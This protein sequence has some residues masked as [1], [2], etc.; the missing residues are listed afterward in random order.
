MHEVKDQYRLAG[1]AVAVLNTLAFHGQARAA[2]EPPI[3][4]VIVSGASDPRQDAVAAKLAYTGIADVA[5]A[6]DV[7]SLPDLTALDVLRRLP[8]VALLPVLDNERPRDTA[9]APVI[10][11]L[12]AA[13]N[14]VTIDGI[15]VASPG[16][17]NGNGSASRGARLNL[18][19]S[20]MI[21][22]MLVSKT[23]LPDQDA[24]GIGG[25][26][27]VR[28]RSAFALGGS[29]FLSVEAALGKPNDAA[30]PHRH[31]R[32][33]QRLA[34][35]AS[36]TFGPQRQ[37]GLVIAASYQATASS[38]NAHMTTDS[39]SE[40]FYNAAGVLQGGA[41]QGNGFAVPQQDKYWYSENRRE[42]Y[43]LAAKLEAK[44]S[45][46]LRG[47]ATGGRFVSRDDMERNELI[48]D[49]RN[50]AKVLGQAA[51][52]GRYPAG[53]VEVGYTRQQATTATSLLQTGLDW[54][55]AAQQV[56]SL[57]AGAS[58]A[59]YREPILMIKYSTGSRNSPPGTGDTSPTP[60]PD[61]A[62]D[63]NT[64]SLDHSF[65]I[66]PAAYYK[67]EN[68]RLNYYRPDSGFHRNAG[69][70]IKY[71]RLDF[72]H[73]GD[74]PGWGYAVGTSF[75]R[76]ASSY[77]LSRT[78]FSPN[79]GA[80]QGTLSDVLGPVGP[81]LIYNQSGLD[82]LTIDPQR[83]A[84]YVDTLRAAGGLN[85]VDQTA[86]GNQ[87]NYEH[88]ERIA[89]A[90]GMLGYAA[91]AWKTRFGVHLDS[92]RQS[93]IGRARVAGAWTD[94]PT[95]SRYHFALPSALASYQWSP[96]LDVRMGASQSIGRPAYD[97]YAARS[98]IDFA[99]PGERGNANATGV[100]VTAGNPDIKP[101]LSTNTDLGVN[102]KLP[103]QAGG[104]LS[105]TVFNKDIKDEIFNASS[106]GYT[107]EGVSYA[108]AVVTKPVN[109]ASASIKGLEISAVVNSLAWLHPAARDFGFSANWTLLKGRM[110]VLKSDKRTRTIGHLTGQP[111]Q[112]RNLSIF[113][114]NGALEL[115]AAYN[116]QGQAL[117][118]VV[119]DIEWQ[120]LYWA[121]RHQV[122]LQASYRLQPGLTL[123]AQ[124]QNL[125]G[126][127][128]TSTVG[129]AGK[130]LKDSHSIPTLYWFGL[131][132]TPAP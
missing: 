14:P 125:T 92:T 62:I 123:L 5:G 132:Y 116:R 51:T 95:G 38:A 54:E 114:G 87:D 43:G 15:P 17:A 45:G 59:S 75:T 25:A 81:G 23:F 89:G 34:G 72:R 67:L 32:I 49:P 66:S 113:Y 106:L 99:N 20:S 42:Q 103:P 124:A 93:T 102:W 98:S 35:T 120:D 8:G 4:E 122:D 19:P 48:I 63:Y 80:K 73:N 50:R 115:R 31:D 55:T 76:D 60:T 18:L 7:Q 64:E 65:N 77:S 117:R 69:N 86:L 100:T 128:L 11:G 107:Y 109:A 101:R 41:N 12:G 3:P 74:G 110:E 108:N 40:S 118:A 2:E 44:F 30:G 112:T 39:T 9:A 96:S 26:I 29:D 24:H 56:A 94:L 22:A 91:N 130:V 47:F 78:Q 36:T 13:Y 33:G 84:A 6:G 71:L 126:E 68:Y 27:D 83:A 88:T 131:R 90:Y 37:F 16:V 105:A 46:T 10:R 1:I 111:G 82:M 52:S 129:A 127:R 61:Y 28:T 85:A 121:P 104:L 21:G 119:P 57:R 97:S 58:R 53:D 70:D 79:T